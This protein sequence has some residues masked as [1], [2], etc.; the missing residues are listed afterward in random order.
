MYLAYYKA[1]CTM[2]EPYDEDCV[3]LGDYPLPDEPSSSTKGNTD[4]ASALKLSAALIF[5]AVVA[6]M[7]F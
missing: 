3:C 7:V 5:A 1:W 2:Y 6:V 4:S